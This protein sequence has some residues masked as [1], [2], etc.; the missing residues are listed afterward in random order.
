MD[1]FFWM[2]MLNVRNIPNISGVLA[3]WICGRLP[4]LGALEILFPR[5]FLRYSDWIKVKE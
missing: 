5:I 2:I 4:L 3:K 1:S